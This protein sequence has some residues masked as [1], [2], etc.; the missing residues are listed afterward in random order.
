L[1]GDVLRK[2]SVAGVLLTERVY[3][4]GLRL[5]E[6]SHRKPD[7]CFVLTG[8][9]TE[10]SG[11]QVRDCRPQSLLF[12]PPGEAHS[13]HFHTSTRCLGLQ[14]E[15][16]RA[17]DLLAGEAKFANRPVNSRGGRLSHLA[18]QLYR[19][20]CLRDAVSPVMIEGLV[21]QMMAET[22]RQ[23]KEATHIAPPWLEQAREILRTQFSNRP[24]LI[25]LARSSGVHPVHLAREFR[26]FYG[27]TISQYVLQRRIDFACHEMSNP[28]ASLIDIALAAGFF[29]QSHFARAFKAQMGMTPTQYRT[30]LRPG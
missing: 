1:H 19:E 15:G 20:F 13:D 18:A 30:T 29:D 14:F 21:L 7:F 23:T 22:F 17:D 12:H 26:R 25:A 9:F 11:Q 27:C 10:I 3:A 6:H 28:R 24:S 5:P 8:S 16:E 4:P 2:A